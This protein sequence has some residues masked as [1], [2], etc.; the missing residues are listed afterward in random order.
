VC[1]EHVASICWCCW[2][3]ADVS[4]DLGSKT[5][6]V[7]FDPSL[8]DAASLAAA[9]AAQ[10][11]YDATVCAGASGSAEPVAASSGVVEGPMPVVVVPLAS[12]PPRGAPSGTGSASQ[13]PLRLGTTVL[14]VDGMSCMGNC[15]GKV[16]RALA[17]VFG[18]TG[19][20]GACLRPLSEGRVDQ[21]LHQVRTLM[22]FLLFLLAVH[23]FPKHPP[24]PNST[25]TRT[26]PRNPPST[27]KR[28]PPQRSV[29]TSQTALW[30]SK[31]APPRQ[32]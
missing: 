18:V 13:G 25:H 17:S 10:A 1:E 32:P 27:A 23:L 19:E 6:T 22:S 26:Q 29:W 21:G 11:G 14:I 24:S 2:L 4:I 16:Q 28:P 20:C 12:G 15:G 31:G 7:V 8:S 30:R 3:C 5:V 9:V